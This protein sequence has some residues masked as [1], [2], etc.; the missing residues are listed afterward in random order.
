M[1][2]TTHDMGEAERL[3]DRI[4]IMDKGKLIALDTAEGMNLPHLRKR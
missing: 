1:I 2:L 4:A 3:C